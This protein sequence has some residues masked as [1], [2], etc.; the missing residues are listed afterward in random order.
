MQSGP[1]TRAPN[2][3]PSTLLC[4][5]NKPHDIYICMYALGHIDTPRSKLERGLL[6]DSRYNQDS[7]FSQ[8]SA[9]FQ[10]RLQTVQRGIM[11]GT[12]TAK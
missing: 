5:T 3:P 7:F 2:P 9:P 11:I 12:A 6:W 8:T 1:L 4:P 10:S